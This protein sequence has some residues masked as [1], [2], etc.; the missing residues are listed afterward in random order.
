M[1]VHPSFRQQSAGTNAFNDAG[2]E[3]E[4]DDV[5]DRN[6]ERHLDSAGAYLR[7][8]FCL[9]NVGV[10][11]CFISISICRAYRV[12]SVSVTVV[13]SWPTKG[14]QCFR[15]KNVARFRIRTPYCVRVCMH[16]LRLFGGL[17][18]PLVI[19]GRE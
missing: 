18:T 12:Y 11:V 3:D 19:V 2:D 5:T 1:F 17:T 14:H 10:R 8:E 7:R 9:K 6:G 15:V 13:S 16:V 4:D